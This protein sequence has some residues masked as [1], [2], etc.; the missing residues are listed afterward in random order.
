MSKRCR[1]CNQL[2]EL[3]DNSDYFHLPP[4]V[5]ECDAMFPFPLEDA[6]TTEDI[7]KF[8]ENITLEQLNDQANQTRYG[9]KA[10]EREYALKSQQFRSEELLLE[11]I[12]ESLCRAKPE[13]GEWNECLDALWDI[14]EEH[15]ENN[16]WRLRK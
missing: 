11:K 13:D 5:E 12:Y 3:N 16:Q 8:Y 14:I 9:V 1:D 7:V 4:M 15:N 10:V 2:I 6:E